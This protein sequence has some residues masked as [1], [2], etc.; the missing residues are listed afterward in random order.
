MFIAMH[1]QESIFIFCLEKADGIYS[2]ASMNTVF[3]INCIK[4]TAFDFRMRTVFIKIFRNIYRL[5]I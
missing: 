3:K 1:F 2:V 4:L 5:F